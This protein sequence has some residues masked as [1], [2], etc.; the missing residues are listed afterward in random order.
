[1]ESRNFIKSIE[2]RD[3]LQ[4]LAL[5]RN[6]S[7]KIV[8]RAKIILM[9]DA[10]KTNT[11][12]AEELHIS[13]PTVILWRKRYKVSGIE[14]ILKDKKR[15]GRSR[16]ITSEKIKEVVEA[17]LNTKPRVAT[18]WSTRTMAKEKGIGKTTVWRIWKA[19]NLK[20]HRIEN[21]KF[22][23]DPNFVEK[24]KDVVG[25]Y[26]NPP[27]K[28]IVLSVD[29]K[30]QIQAL[31]RTQLLLPLR[32]GIPAR[33]THDYKR[34]GITT[35]FTA[36]NV[37]DGKV[38]GKCYKRHRHQE[39]I[40][41]LREI[42]R[43]I[44]KELDLHLIVDNYGTR[45]HLKVK[46]WLRRHMRFHLHFTPTGASWANIVERWLRELTVKRIRR[47]SFPSVS[48]L[49]EAIYEYIEE[50]NKEPKP[51]VWKASVNSIL[52]K[53]NYCKELYGTSH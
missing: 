9:A 34:N 35:L 5:S 38:I 32:P 17:T 25:L 31:E 11:R 23:K 33:Q 40:K 2:E 26:M 21:F 42:N 29:E 6:A 43:T 7:Y 52:G 13:R 39:F 3:K 14:G 46:S 44:P 12:I 24:L 16:I 30:S 22:S 18:H 41:F 53:I 51:F 50:N 28:A 20:P 8:I 27:D 15:N 37:L 45:K 19:G 4:K 36:L 47:A 49:V 1:M 10:G 48:K